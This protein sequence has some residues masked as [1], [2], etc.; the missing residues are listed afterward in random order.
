MDLSGLDLCKVR[1][2]H[3]SQNM[4]RNCIVNVTNKS[5]IVLVAVMSQY[6]TPG[7]LLQSSSFAWKWIN[8]MV[9]YGFEIV[10]IQPCIKRQTGSNSWSDVVIVVGI[11]F[12]YLKSQYHTTVLQE[13]FSVHWPTFFLFMSK[14]LLNAMLPI[15]V[16]RN[17]WVR[18]VL[19]IQETFLQW[20]TTTCEANWNCSSSYVNWPE[21]LS[22]RAIS[23]LAWSLIGNG[24]WTDEAF[25][26]IKAGLMLPLICWKF[27]KIIRKMY[28]FE[29]S[30]RVF[31][32]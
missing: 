5:A 9:I 6:V 20:S 26:I 3:F 10:E 11:I 2:T 4:A 17:C 25:C 23:C 19:K 24:L 1:K 31:A 22:I 15:R 27:K 13:L 29:K 21:K 7:N 32:C 28:A 18:S 8:T 12:F 30:H 16:I 14:I